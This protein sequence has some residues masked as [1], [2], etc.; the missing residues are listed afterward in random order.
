MGDNMGDKLDLCNTGL[1][2][3]FYTSMLLIVRCFKSIN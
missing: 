2:K 1:H 3:L